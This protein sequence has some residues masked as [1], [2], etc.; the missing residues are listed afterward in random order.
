MSLST[1]VKISGVNNLSDA[2]YCAGMGAAILGFCPEENHPDYVDPKKFSDITGWIQGVKLAGE[3]HNSTS[4]EVREISSAYNFDFIQVSSV[5][6]VEDLSD[7]QK[8]VLFQFNLDILKDLSGLREVMEKY[9]ESIIYF[10]F[11]GNRVS[12]EWVKLIGRMSEKFPILYGIDVTG[13]NVLD[14]LKLYDFHGL[15]LKGGSEIK[16][17][18][19]DF[20]ELAE[21][22]ELLDAGN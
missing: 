8:P 21:I 17:G 15:S 12:Q 16:P 19:Y 14:L 20:G 2:R 7:L 6:I 9:K 3:F 1:L 10:V 22:M 4:R 18:Y 11:E 13:N 5:G